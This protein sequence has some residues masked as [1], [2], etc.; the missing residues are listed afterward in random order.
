MKYLN[1]GTNVKV[2]GF[3]TNSD[4]S[5]DEQKHITYERDYIETFAGRVGVIEFID[6]S[7]THPYMV[8][9]G[10]DAKPIRTR[11]SKEELI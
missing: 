2:L 8:F 4:Y 1:V 3:K 11:F 9:F 6:D 10:V 5:T 7:D